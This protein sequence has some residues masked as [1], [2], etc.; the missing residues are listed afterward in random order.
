MTPELRQGLLLEVVDALQR[1]DS[2]AALALEKTIVNDVPRWKCPTCPAKWPGD[3]DAG[4]HAKGC[5][6]DRSTAYA[7]EAVRICGHLLDDATGS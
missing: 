7:R 6:W 2:L 3:F 5:S 1:V 4:L